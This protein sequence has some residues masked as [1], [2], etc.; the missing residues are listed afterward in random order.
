MLGQAIFITCWGIASCIRLPYQQ[1]YRQEKFGANFHSM[2]DTIMIL[3][4]FLGMLIIPF[5]YISS[6]LIDFADYSIPIWAILLGTVLQLVGIYV[7]YYAH[8]DLGK[9]YSG[10]VELREGHKLVT[11]GIYSIIRHPMYAA[12]WLLVLGQALLLGNYLAA[13]SGILGFGF[14]YITRIDREEEMLL[15]KFGKEYREYMESTGRLFPKK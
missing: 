6:S 2:Q 15:Q 14:L 11:E 12:F 10:L 8:R 7:F 13:F 1:A 4:A 3:C 5:W 9:N